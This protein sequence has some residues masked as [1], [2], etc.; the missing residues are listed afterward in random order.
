MPLERVTVRWNGGMLERW[1]GMAER[2]GGTHGIFKNTEY[3]EHSKT[4][5]ILNIFKRRIYGIF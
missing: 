2:N 5:K 4:R 1:N 3:T